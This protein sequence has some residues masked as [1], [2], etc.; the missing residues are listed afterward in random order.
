MKNF[1]GLLEFGKPWKIAFDK[2]D[3][4]DKIKLAEST[5]NSRAVARS[6]N[7]GGHLVLWWA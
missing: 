5:V 3:L 4:Y 2:S 7:P 1:A 6:E